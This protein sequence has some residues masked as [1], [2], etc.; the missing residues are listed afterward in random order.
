MWAEV[1]SQ[2]VPVP[3]TVDGVEILTALVNNGA[4]TAI[5]DAADST[6]GTQTVPVGCSLI[7]AATGALSAGITRPKANAFRQIQIV[8]AAGTIHDLDV[9]AAYLAVFGVLPIVGSYCYF[10][11][12]LVSVVTGQVGKKVQIFAIIS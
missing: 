12:G 9:T 4:G 10:E 5:I 2:Y 1:Y 8:P 3:I 11:I 6:L 7:V